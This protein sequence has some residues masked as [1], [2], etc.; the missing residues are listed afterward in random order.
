MQ[1]H[2]SKIHSND[3]RISAFLWLFV[4]IEGGANVAL[5]WFEGVAVD[6]LAYNSFS[7][8]QLLRSMLFLLAAIVAQWASSVLTPFLFKIS[9]A[10]HISKLR[11]RI[12]SV[13]ISAPVLRLPR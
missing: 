6:A 11:R 10:Q 2:N 12:Y 3:M 4:L 5:A 7:E 1:S 8:Q 13:L 9:C